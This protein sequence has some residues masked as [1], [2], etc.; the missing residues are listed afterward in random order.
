MFLRLCFPVH[1]DAYAKAQKDLEEPKSHFKGGKWK[2]W[3]IS[4]YLHL[5]FLGEN[6][7]QAL[8]NQRATSRPTRAKQKCTTMQREGMGAKRW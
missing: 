6:C 5:N 8:L 1:M 4:V 3:G 2:C 7:T